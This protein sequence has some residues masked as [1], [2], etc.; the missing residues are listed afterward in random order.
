MATKAQKP[1]DEDHDADHE[2]GDDHDDA[3]AHAPMAKTAAA[4]AHVPHGATKGEIVRIFL[5]LIVLTAIELGVVYLPISKKA[6]V[7]ALVLLALSKAYTVAMYYMH[8]KGETRIMKFVVYG[9]M[10][11]PPLYAVIL[12]LEAGFRFFRHLFG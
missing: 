3:K 5:I 7:I 6:I 2:H 10:I 8:L 9:P 11:F 12:M 4:A 1:H